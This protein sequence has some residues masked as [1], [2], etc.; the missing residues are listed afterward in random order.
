M[1]GFQCNNETDCREDQCCLFKTINST[2][3][4][5]KRLRRER[6][7]CAIPDDDGVSI[8]RCPCLGNLTCQ[9]NTSNNTRSGE[10]RDRPAGGREEDREPRPKKPKGRDRPT[11]RPKKEKS[12]RDRPEKTRKKDR[13]A[14]RPKQ[15]RQ[16]ERR[17]KGRCM[18]A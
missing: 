15:G 7:S 5:C 2:T 11:R 13:P 3:G 18:S 10:D 16:P 9:T 14:K 12:D 6:Q 1:C 17:D 8:S 4:K